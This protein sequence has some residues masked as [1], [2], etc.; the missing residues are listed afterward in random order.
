MCRQGSDSGEWGY[1]SGDLRG[2]TSGPP[3]QR[4]AGGTSWGRVGRGMG[5]ETGRMC[6]GLVSPS[7]RTEWVSSAPDPIEILDTL[8]LAHARIAIRGPGTVVVATTIPIAGA[9]VLVVVV[10]VAAL[11]VTPL[12]SG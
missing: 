1:Y 5:V 11:S 4:E 2:G 6:L 7:E 10:V 12:G 3:R 9:L 8:S